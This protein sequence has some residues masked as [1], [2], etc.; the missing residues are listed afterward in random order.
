M[1]Q[2]IPIVTFTPVSTQAEGSPFSRLRY[3]R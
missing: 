2:T 1:E 3:E